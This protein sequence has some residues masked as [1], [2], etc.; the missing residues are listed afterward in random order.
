MAIAAVHGVATQKLHAFTHAAER[1]YVP[2]MQSA[3]MQSHHVLV[4]MQY[5]VHAGHHMHAAMTT[6]NIP[7]RPGRVC[8]M[9]HFHEIDD[10]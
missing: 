6:G 2:N 10:S 1:A 5:N 9:L 3:T 8:S 4:F 7:T